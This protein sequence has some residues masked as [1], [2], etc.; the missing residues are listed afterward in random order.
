M[1]YA[2][3]PEQGEP[4]NELV[5]IIRGQAVFGSDQH[6]GVYAGVISWKVLSEHRYEFMARVT[7]EAPVV[8][9]LVSGAPVSATPIIVSGAIDP[10]NP[11]QVAAIDIDGV[12]IT[13]TITA[14]GPCHALIRGPSRH[15]DRRD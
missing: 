12:V 1:N 7:C 3:G 15:H 6:G 11:R 4:R 5:L 14:L 13:A 8:G 10:T 9:E 2:D